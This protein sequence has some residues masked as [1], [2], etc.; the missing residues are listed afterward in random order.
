MIEK[1]KQIQE[2][3][4][5]RKRIQFISWDWKESPLDKFEKALEEFG[6]HMYPD[7]F[8]EGSDTE[9]F[10]LSEKKLTKEQIEKL[11]KRY[12]N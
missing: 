3:L 4:G 12:I 5:T 7:P 6:I 10:I 1:E 11:C 8:Y 2:A 9:A